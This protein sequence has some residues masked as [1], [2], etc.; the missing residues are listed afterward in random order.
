MA[1]IGGK[2]V[3][4]GESVTVRRKVD[5]KWKN[6][7]IT[8]T[9]KDGKPKPDMSK[10]T[11]T[12]TT[13]SG[14]TISYTPPAKPPEWKPAQDPRKFMGKRGKYTRPIHPKRTITVYSGYVW[15]FDY[16]NN[17]WMAV[18][19]SGS[20]DVAKLTGGTPPPP[21]EDLKKKEFEKK[22]IEMDVTQ[23]TDLSKAGMTE[24][25]QKVGLLGIYKE[26]ERGQERRFEKVQRDIE[27]NIDEAKE[28]K[29]EIDK[30]LGDLSEKEKYEAVEV[31]TAGGGKRV[32]LVGELREELKSDKKDI[33]KFIS[34]AE[35]TYK[36]NITSFEQVKSGIPPKVIM[37]T[38]AEKIPEG[39]TPI[40]QKQ[41][42]LPPKEDTL[43]SILG[44]EPKPSHIERGIREQNVPYF[45]TLTE[46]GKYGARLVTDVPEFVTK[47]V[48][49]IATDP[50]GSGK[51]MHQQILY[52]AKHKPYEIA[53]MGATA[54]ALYKAPTPKFI[55]KGLTKGVRGVGRGGTAVMDFLEGTR[56]SQSAKALRTE[57]K[58]AFPDPIITLETIQKGQYTSVAGTS[59]GAG[60]VELGIKAKKPPNIIDLTVSKITG[61]PAKPKVTVYTA[62]ADLGYSITPKDLLIPQLSKEMSHISGLS[63]ADVSKMVKKTTAKRSGELIKGYEPKSLGE[64]VGEYGGTAKRSIT[65]SPERFGTEINV[66]DVT[67]SGFSYRFKPAVAGRMADRFKTELLGFGAGKGRIISLDIPTKIKGV[68][69]KALIGNIKGKTLVTYPKK[70]K[71]AEIRGKQI[72]GKPPTKVTPKYVGKID[73]GYQFGLQETRQPNIATRFARGKPKTPLD[74][75]DSKLA[76][77]STTPKV[78]F[79]KLDP[80]IKDIA[81]GG[82]LP[83]PPTT[84]S[85]R[86][87][88]RYSRLDMAKLGKKAR[89]GLDYDLE[90]LRTA[91]PETTAGIVGGIKQTFT[92]AK[93]LI[94]EDVATTVKSPKL[95]A[96]K[97]ITKIEAEPVSITK[98][99]SRLTPAI[100][101]KVSQRTTTKYGIAEKSILGIAQ[102][103]TIKSR[104]ISTPKAIPKLRIKTLLKPIPK[105]KTFTKTAFVPYFP[106][107]PPSLLTAPP[108]IL[109]KGGEFKPIIERRRK[110]KKIKRKTTKRGILPL[111][112]W[113]SLTQTE[114]RKFGKARHLAPT[115]KVKKQF[116]R[117]LK[118]GG[119]SFRF[120]TFEQ[121]KGKRRK[122]R[123]II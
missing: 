50:I 39:I 8:V 86:L 73:K 35:K 2:Q 7:T 63:V 49:A 21:L 65:Y 41:A 19:R 32:L 34:G 18:G 10:Y 120:P 78:E 56:F 77:P 101:T 30:M 105:T 98:T 114:S 28:N 59:R 66:F 74:F 83:P 109:H 53:L 90:F 102:K 33:D 116:E 117:G 9:R 119:V 100:R 12:R 24:L 107:P 16:D 123:R 31:T 25:G 82:G 92:G 94:L 40:I 58:K 14:H 47:G 79:V 67:S 118:F 43:T 80:T 42:L 23:Q 61:K 62:K 55:G 29:K 121:A 111:A 36:E 69:Y 93:G 84:R 112:D 11:T 76:S 91:P 110:K 60:Y 68:E 45:E 108:I 52:S 22:Q 115:P 13:P 57:Y 15:R 44:L 3:K 26:L 46:A 99:S 51:S 20:P 88:M 95:F 89:G 37:P 64:V 81:T 72:V 27:E 4:S 122:I 71:L 6:V 103:P 97:P 70:I 85:V 104:A 17:R 113:L 54:V 38:Y 48:P 87:D 106:K 75:K 5:G 1:I 96:G